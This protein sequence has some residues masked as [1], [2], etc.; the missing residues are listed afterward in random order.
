MPDIGWIDVAGAATFFST[1]YGAVAR[2]QLY[3][4]CIEPFNS[5]SRMPEGR[6]V[7]VFNPE[8]PQAI[9]SRLGDYFQQ[10]P[11]AIGD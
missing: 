3:T 1:R 10:V 9:F 7:K 5:L 2:R 4:K 6:R 11:P 8:W